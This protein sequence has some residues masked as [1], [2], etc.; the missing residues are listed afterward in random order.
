YESKDGTKVPMF[1]VHKSGLTL[2]GDNPVLLYGYGGFNI[3]RR[4]AY[5]TSWVF[6]LEQGGILALPNLRG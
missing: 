4:P 2:N 3:S 6:W 5:S 1:L